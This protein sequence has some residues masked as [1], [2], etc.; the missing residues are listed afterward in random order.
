MAT[1][2]IQD[3]GKGGVIKDTPP[4]ILPE[5]ILTDARNVRFNN[6]SIQSILGDGTYRVLTAITPEYGI[7]WRRPDQ[8]YDIFLNDGIG[9][10][11]DAGGSESVVLNSA[12]AKY[13]NSVWDCIT[14]NGGYAIVINNGKSTP[15]YMLYGDPTAGTAFQELPNW[16]YV[17]G[18]T[19][20]AKVV[21][22]LGYS[23][24]A[25]NLTLVDGGITT[26][27]PSTIRI[28]TQASTGNIP[29]T[30]A[31][32]LTTDTA[33]EFEVSS[34]SP[35]LDMQ[36]LRGNMYIYSSDAINVLSLRGG[37]ASVAPYSG[38]HG[39]LNTGCVVEFEGGHFVVDS[40]D[41]YT[42]SGSGGFKSLVEGRMKD[43][44]FDN[45][46]RSA[47]DKVFVKLNPLYKEIWVFYP[48]GASTVCNEV[49][50][51]NYS[52]DTW[53]M[54]DI[55]S[56]LSGFLGP[57]LSGGAYGYS[58]KELH[59]IISGKKRILKMDDGNS[60]YNAT[61]DAFSAMTAYVVRERLNT[62]DTSGSVQVSALLPVFDKT[63]P[64]A[65]MSVIMTS[66]NNYS[67]AAD[68]S[69]TSG[70]D[71]TTID[72]SSDASGYRVDPRVAGRVLN[73]KITGQAPWRLALLGIDVQQ[74]GKR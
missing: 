64:G 14:Y 31:P 35:I 9:Y 70:R 55:D 66:Q 8:G 63:T 5:N 30:W 29:D 48:K 28:S 42:H 45:L 26:Y 23:L 51:Y 50:I 1:K 61:T 38:D 21:R 6:N 25:A 12:D 19:V 71:T 15:L 44:F 20:T 2:Q 40:N 72:P 59:V 60:L 13:T 58:K 69:D 37:V 49:M 57:A 46:N 74:S 34:T 33:D 41:I 73:Y 43:Y 7:H 3:L 17:A 68:F 27:A 67:D 22:S 47:Y 11:V 36:E 65:L 62:G 39:V 56:A 52:T 4:M 32:G 18:L 16:N 10:R 24:V 54:R 53:T